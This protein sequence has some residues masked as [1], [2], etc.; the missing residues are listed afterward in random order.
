MDEVN[1]F[2]IERRTVYLAICKLKDGIDH[3]N[4]HSNH[5]KMIGTEF[6]DFFF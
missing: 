2:F 5:I 3:S 6:R 4:M 1:D